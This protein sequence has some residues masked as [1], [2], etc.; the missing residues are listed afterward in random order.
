MRIVSVLERTSCSRPLRCLLMRPALFQ[1]R[2]MF[3]DRSETHLVEVGQARNRVIMD[4][5][6]DDDVT[7]RAV[8]QSMEKQV[9]L[10][11]LFR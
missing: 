9:G 2:H 10:L 4:H 1:D 7:T 8:G 11:L 3:L 6:L 5:C